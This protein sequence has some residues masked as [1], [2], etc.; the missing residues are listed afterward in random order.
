M[1]DNTIVLPVDVLNDG[2]TEDLELRRYQEL[3]D[4]SVYHG[5]DHSS[6]H[7]SKVELYRTAA[8]P[9]GTSRGINR[10]M[11]KLT[12][13]VAVDTTVIGEQ[14]IADSIN[15]LNFAIPVGASK[16]FQ[17]IIRQR[18]IAILDDDTIM[19]RFMDAGEI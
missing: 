3:T 16:D 9:S 5:P 14:A 10:R 1:L 13:S 7:K 8:K 18:F 2:T 17:K 15:S 6:T 12:E 4:K 19:D 11:I